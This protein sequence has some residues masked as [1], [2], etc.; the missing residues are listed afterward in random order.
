[1][2]TKGVMLQDITL[3]TFEYCFA[4]VLFLA[5][6]IAASSANAAVAP[7]SKAIFLKQSETRS[8]PYHH[9]NCQSFAS[10]TK[11][12]LSAT[13]IRVTNKP[14]IGI[15]ITSDELGDHSWNTGRRDGSRS[16]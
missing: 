15:P 14:I 12:R 10:F 7:W 11:T 13:I 6:G 9:F 8:R 4:D 16:Q 1:M 5:D 3:C 2:K